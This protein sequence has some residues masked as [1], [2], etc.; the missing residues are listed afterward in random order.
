MSLDQLGNPGM[1]KPTSSARFYPAI[2]LSA[3]RRRQI[4]G[5]ELDLDDVTYDDIL[6]ST[7]SAF[8][9]T[10]YALIA[11][12]EERWGKDAG[13]ELAN[14]LGARNGRRNM[15]RWLAAK[16]VTKGSP[17]LMSNF[18][19]FQ[20]GMR[21]PDHATALSTYDET[22][23]KV[24]RTRCAWHN[25]RP[26][27]A[28]SYCRYF[29]ETAVAGYGGADPALVEIRIRCCMSWGDGHCEHEF[30]FDTPPETGESS[31]HVWRREGGSP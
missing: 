24:Y 13:R 20:H 9:G 16:G 12:V 8:T 3:E 1:Y 4:L 2:T 17:M 31:R 11:I 25:G 7:A 23:A 30:W 10:F 29:S 28:E 21:G 14:E 6:F 22:H 27:G 19:D 15:E 5:F 26:E 18:Q